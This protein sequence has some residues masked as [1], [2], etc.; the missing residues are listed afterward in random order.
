MTPSVLA[1]S[2]LLLLCA[3]AHAGD[4][5]AV[6]NASLLPGWERVGRAARE[7]LFSPRTWVPL[8][9]AGLLQVDDLDGRISDWAADET[10][11]FGSNDRAEDFS[12]ATQKVTGGLYVAT[13]LVAPGPSEWREWTIVK[14]KALGIALTAN[15]VKEESVSALKDA[16]GRPRPRTREDDSFPSSAATGAAFDTAMIEGNLDTMPMPDRVRT[17]SKAGLY[18]ITVSTA[19]S[20]VEAG[21]HFPSDVLVGMALGHFL[22]TFVTKAFLN[23]DAPGN[24]VVTGGPAGT[25]GLGVHVTF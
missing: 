1:T 16:A 7:A 19:W 14:G 17:A 22:G 10:P 24:V 9:G 25:L 2:L 12:D 8:A 6:S 5:P 18:L 11:L 4:P 20:R 21:A 3:C 15:L 23:E 13:L